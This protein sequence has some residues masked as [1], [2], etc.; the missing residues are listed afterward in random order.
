MKSIP[1]IRNIMRKGPKFYWTLAMLKKE[2]LKYG[3]RNDWRKANCGSYCSAYR[4]ELLDECCSHMIPTR[5]GKRWIV[6]SNQ[7]YSSLSQV[8]KVL[9]VKRQKVHYH[10]VTGKELL[11]HKLSYYDWE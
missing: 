11:G 4:Q 3:S 1:N 8:A 6:L 7:I 9:G 10:L 5:S 2:A